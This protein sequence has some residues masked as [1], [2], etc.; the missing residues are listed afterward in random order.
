VTAAKQKPSLDDYIDV[1][2]RIAA[3]KAAHP[4]GSL[5][6]EG[7]EIREVGNRLFIVYRALAFRSPDDTRP[8]MGT[9]WEPFP[10]PTP[11]TRDSELMNAE[12]AAWGRAIVAV[13]ITA[14]R[15]IASRQEVA[16]RGDKQQESDLATPAQRATLEA[17]IRRAMNDGMTLAVL[18]GMLDD[19]GLQELEIKA[20]W[21]GQLSGEQAAALTKVLQSGVLPD[22]ALGSDIPTDGE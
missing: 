4:D 14:N 18:R 21:M 2:E 12:T 16:A 3:F 17:L 7:W 15:R 11:Y 1:A 19:Q 5:Q 13:G 22:P 20:G 8:G 10:G 9:A 6:T